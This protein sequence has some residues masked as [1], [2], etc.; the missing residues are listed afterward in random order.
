M[1]T[2]SDSQL[3]DQLVGRVSGSVLAPDHAD[4]E[5][6]RAVHN[7]LVDRRPVL[8]V[9]ARRAEDVVAA[10]A[11]ARSGGFEVSVRGGGHNV[12]GRAVTDGGVMI[13][14]A[15]M[16]HI[17][18]DPERRT[19]TAQGGVT[20]NELNEAAARHGLAVTGGAVSTTGIAGYTLGGGLGWLMG[21]HG[22]ACDNL[23]AVE[24]VSAA[25][26]V[27]HV[28]ADSHP[29]LLWALRGGGGNFGVAT[30]FTYRLHPLSTVT[31]GLIAHPIDAAPD[32]LRFYRDAVADA[33]D[34]LTVFAGL[35]H[36][37]D[38]SGAKLAAL[39][40]CHAG[41]PD[42][43]AQELAPFLSFGAPLMT[44]VGPMPYPQMNTLLDAGYPTGSLNYWLSSFTHGLPDALI[45]AVV[46][47]FAS[48]PS[49]MT[50]ILL[51]HFHGAVTRVAPTDTAVPHREPGWNLLIP[52]V[53]TDPAAT[54]TNIRWTRQTHAALSPHLAA[55]RWLNYL[56]DDQTNDAVQA[57]YG[58]NYDRLREIKRRYD[59]TN[60][61]HLNHNIAP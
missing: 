5:A 10:L 17:T 53:W 56:G 20:W 41:D 36:A 37:P 1:T 45:D 48:V 42:T 54:D 38:G 22:L 47:R 4:Y 60:L 33:S 23:E 19:A 35:V 29:E 61:F 30:S 14:L 3:L 59:P 44:A 2:T 21:K 28:A 25:G 57:A 39:I 49:T 31:G 43:A 55:R 50:A 52:S 9:R 34:D 46:Q 12:A 11:F 32:L 15:E 26:D 6:A 58:P 51:E 27:L 7:G 16:K 18:V 24:L 40:V 13:D 8:I